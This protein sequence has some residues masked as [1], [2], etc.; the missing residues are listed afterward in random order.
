MNRIFISLLML[1]TTFSA[2]NLLNAQKQKDPIA[3]PYMVDT[4]T[5]ILNGTLERWFGFG[6][7]F[8]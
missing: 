5:A 2:V 6:L 1:I 3:N 4:K 8:I 7:Y